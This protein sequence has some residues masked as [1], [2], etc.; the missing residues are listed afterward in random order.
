[1]MKARECGGRWRSL[2][3]VSLVAWL[4]VPAWAQEVP[5]QPRNHV[6]DLAGVVNSNTEAQLNRLLLELEQK[7]G[8]QVVVLTLGTTGGEPID[9]FSFDLGDKWQLGQA[10]KDNGVLITIAVQ[11]RKSWI[12]TGKGIGGALPDLLVHR[13]QTELMVPH[14]KRNDYSGGIHAGAGAVAQAIAN[15]A[16][17]TLSGVPASARLPERSGQGSAA[18]G[19]GLFGIIVLLFFVRVFAGAAMGRRRWSGRGMPW[20]GWLLIASTMSSRGRGGGFGGGFD[21]GG[22]FGGFGG[23]S[24]GGGGGGSFGGG[25]AGASW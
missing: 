17:V 6:E 20:W 21:G 2:V 7:T 13:V 10:D 8:A 23:G 25:G 19:R 14:F 4:A 18:C 16:G 24:F 5:S 9:E 3:V 15:E 1:M 12:A 11:D 22:G